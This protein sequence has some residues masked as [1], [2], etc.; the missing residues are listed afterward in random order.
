MRPCVLVRGQS[1]EARENKPSQGYGGLANAGPGWKPDHKGRQRNLIAQV[2]SRIFFSF[3]NLGGGGGETPGRKRPSRDCRCRRPALYYY[4]GLTEPGQINGA[5]HTNLSFPPKECD[6]CDH[7]MRQLDA[8][9]RLGRG[10]H[11]QT[12]T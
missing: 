1:P 12:K 3:L 11:Q 5:L 4:L 10:G 8:D 2:R 6:S 7:E 9:P